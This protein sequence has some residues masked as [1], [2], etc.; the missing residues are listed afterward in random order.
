M[1]LRET[2]VRTFNGRR[3]LVPNSTV[4]G[5]ILTVQTGYTHIRTTVVI[6]VDYATDL[7][8][9]RS[10][11]LEAVH[12]VPGVVGDPPPQCLLTELAASTINFELRLWSGA[13][14]LEALETRNRVIERVAGALIDA[15]V[16]MPAEIRVVQPSPDLMAAIQRRAV[17]ES[18]GGVADDD[19]RP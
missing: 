3:V 13:R 16:D 4:H 18:T 17:R 5:E 19:G 1:N 12:G 10:V 9:A 2:V 15:G 6:G 8:L 7:A 14:Q 11:A